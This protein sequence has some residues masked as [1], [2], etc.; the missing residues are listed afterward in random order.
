MEDLRYHEERTSICSRRMTIR[1]LISTIGNVT[2]DG[3]L[4]VSE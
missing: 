2:L 4:R 1:D 3:R